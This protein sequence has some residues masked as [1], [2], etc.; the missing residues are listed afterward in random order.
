M[1]EDLE[2]AN[3][4]ADL[5]EKELEQAKDQL[6]DIRTR[7]NLTDTSTT[8]EDYEQRLEESDKKIASKEYEIQRLVK[9]ADKLSNEM[10]TKE[11]SLAA[12][13]DTL[14]TQ[15]KEYGKEISLL[16]NKLQKQNDYDSIKRDLAIL[17]SL[18]GDNN[19][20]EPSI[21]CSGKHA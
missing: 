5:Y 19:A 3:Q 2:K 4:K 16:Q 20:D 1:L 21:K 14:D 18:E 17:R 7:E 8:N 15:N 9:K 10:E 13:I 11:Y 6:K 12:R